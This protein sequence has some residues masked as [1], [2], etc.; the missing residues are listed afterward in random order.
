MQPKVGTLFIPTPGIEECHNYWLVQKLLD[1]RVRSIMTSTPFENN[2][3]QLVE[4][5]LTPPP[6]L[7]KPAD[8]QRFYEM[9]AQELY[10]SFANYEQ[11]PGF[12]EALKT[13]IPYKG[14]TFSINSI[15]TVGLSM[16]IDLDEG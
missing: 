8:I 5:Y 6:H 7:T 11:S 15:T 14:K 13:L 1:G 9:E 3:R 12:Q 10:G 16:I 4:Y 2:A